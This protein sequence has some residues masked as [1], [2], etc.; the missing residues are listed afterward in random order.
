MLETL[1]IF[2]AEPDIE[3]ASIKQLVQMLNVDLSRFTFMI[4]AAAEIAYFA[5]K[6][7]YMPHVHSLVDAI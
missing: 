7:K 2:Q 4:V 3:E 6:Y 5:L 1:V